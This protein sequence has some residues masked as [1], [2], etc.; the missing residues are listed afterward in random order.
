MS[1]HSKSRPRRKA[2]A[3]IKRAD[4]IDKQE[5]L[6]S[7]CIAMN[8]LGVHTVCRPRARDDDPE[9]HYL[10]PYHYAGVQVSA[11]GPIKCSELGV[12]GLFKLK[13]IALPLVNLPPQATATFH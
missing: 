11:A 12:R 3:S 13:A 10:P 1:Q 8:A 9:L 5:R 7:A 2:G 4:A 6:I